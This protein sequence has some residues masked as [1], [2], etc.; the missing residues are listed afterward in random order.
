M[1]PDLAHDSSYLQNE[2][3]DIKQQFDDESI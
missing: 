2:D 1:N 3:E